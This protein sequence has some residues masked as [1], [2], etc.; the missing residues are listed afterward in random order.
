M[1]N[2]DDPFLCELEEEVKRERY[3]KLWDQYGLYAIAGVVAIVVAIGAYQYIAGQRRATAEAAGGTFEQAMEAIAAGKPDDAI[4]SL[5]P[6]AATGPSGYAALARLQL[7]GAQF[8]AGKTAEALQ[9]Y[10]A[11]AA[12][13]QADAVLR[14]FARLQAAS[15]R[16]N[17]ADFAEIKNRLTPLLA[18]GSAWRA[19]ARELVGIAAV[20]AGKIEE[21]RGAF[22]LLLKD[23]A[24]PP[25]MQERAR[26]MMAAITA[27]ESP[28][29]PEKASAAPAPAAGAASTASNGE[30]AKQ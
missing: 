21:A 29:A 14:D 17:E 22:E 4:K 5:E 15:V 27:M 8:A 13:E 26:T 7:A 6:L 9:S 10:E 28:A 3:A 24:T 25:S 11:L 23:R 1:A 12:D 20:K 16:M 2:K 19:P 18:D 30:S